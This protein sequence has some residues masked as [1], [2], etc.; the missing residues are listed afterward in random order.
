MFLFLSSERYR[1]S[2]VSWRFCGERGVSHLHQKRPAGCDVPKPPQCHHP[3]GPSQWHCDTVVAQSERS[4]RE[5][6]LPSG[7]RALCGCRQGGHVSQATLYLQAG[8]NLTCTSTKTQLL[9]F[10]GFYSYMVTSGMD[11]KLKVY[12]VR[13]FKPLKSYFI[14]A[15]ASCLSLSQRGLLSAATGD[16]V[17]VGSKSTLRKLGFLISL[18]SRMM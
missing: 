5:D 2:T 7:S 13:A 10:C 16:V 12:D 6:A 17:Q 3:P 11:K 15:G 4:A 8:T 14:P 9:L 18:F 1:L